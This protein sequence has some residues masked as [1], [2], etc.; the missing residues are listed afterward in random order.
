MLSAVPAMAFAQHLWR[1]P[2]GTDHLRP[3]RQPLEALLV[4]FPV[5]SGARLEINAV[6]PSTKSDDCAAS[7]CAFSSRCSCVSRSKSSEPFSVLALASVQH[8]FDRS[9]GWVRRLRSLVAT[10][11]G[12][13]NLELAWPCGYSRP[14]STMR[15]RNRRVACSLG[16][17]KMRSG[18]PDST[19]TPPSRKQTAFATSRAKPISWVAI[20]IVM[21]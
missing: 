18:E 9:T 2:L 11:S 3:G 13:A 21:P 20:S 4:H 16:S 15:W 6:T 5:N 17:L 10:L 8:P 1:Q 14:A 12:A 19:M 7:T